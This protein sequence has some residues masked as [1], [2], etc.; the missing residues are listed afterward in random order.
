MNISEGDDQDTIAAIAD[1]AGR[2]LLD[3]HSDPHHNRSVLTLVGEEAPRRVAAATVGRLDLTSHRG[4][5]P[6]TGVVDVVPFVPLSGATMADAVAARDSFAAWAARELGVPSFL[7]GTERTLPD[8]RRGA[9]TDL[10]PDHGDG[11]PHPT[12][13][14]M[15]VGARPVL[16]AYNVWLAQPDLEL[17]NAVARRI[18][19]P[20][21]RTL[22]LEVGERVQVSMN[23][24]SPETV[25]PAAATDA[26][27]V[28]AA[29]A[30]CELVGLLPQAVLEGIEPE[31]WAELDLAEDRTIEARLARREAKSRQRGRAN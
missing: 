25:D 6:R 2:D 3:V 11:E 28:H 19:G 7:Y 26:V 13:G 29:V 24:I 21:L 20:Y 27:A 5:H 30:G 10:L 31:R 4:A 12:A 8:I 18:R 15:A 9:F 23:L 16:I 22:G 14:A 1:S 17:A